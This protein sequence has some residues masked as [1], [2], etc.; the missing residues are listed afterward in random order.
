MLS[1]VRISF[2]SCE[3]SC[4]Y[5]VVAALEVRTVKNEKGK[6]RLPL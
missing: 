2:L 3:G 1:L 6:A 5:Y 4:H